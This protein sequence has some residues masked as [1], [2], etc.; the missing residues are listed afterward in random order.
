MNQRVRAGTKSGADSSIFLLRAVACW[1]RCCSLANWIWPRPKVPSQDGHRRSLPSNDRRSAS[2]P[3]RRWPEKIVFD[4]NL[5]T[6][7]P[8]P[9]PASQVA[10]CPAAGRSCQFSARC[11]RRSQAGG[12]AGAA[13]EAAG[14]ARHRHSRPDHY[15]RGR[16]PMA[17]GAEASAF[18]WSDGAILVSSARW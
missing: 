3:R 18:A 5:P 1:S 9:A 16:M 13:A 7:V 4:T 15:N 14:K 11:P 12:A 8:P 10:A 2:S 6:I 17:D